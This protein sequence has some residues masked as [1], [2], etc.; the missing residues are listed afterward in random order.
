MRKALLAVLACLAVQL[1]AVAGENVEIRFSWWGAGERHENTL[2]AIKL[3]EAKNPGVTVKAEYMGWQGYVERLTTQIGSASEPDVMQINWAWIDMFSPDGKGLY[4][5]NQVKDSVNLADFSESMINSGMSGGALNGLPVSMTTR[6]WIWNKTM[7]DKAGAALPKTW[8]DLRDAG[9]KFKAMGDKFYAT[10]L[11]PIEG[12]YMVIAWLHDNFGGQIIHPTEPKIGVTEAQLVD[13]IRYFKSLFDSHAAVPAPVRTSIAG[14]YERPSEQ[15]GEFI[16]GTWAGTFVWNSMFGVRTGGAIERGSNMVLG[17]MLTEKGTNPKPDRI[18]RP[19]MMFAVSKNSKNP[20]LAAKLVS[21]LLTDPEGAKAM[22][23]ARGLPVAK[24]AYDTLM[25]EGLV[26][27]MDQEGQR[28]LDGATIVYTSPLFEHERIR[29]F[30]LNELEAV[31]HGSATP[32]QAAKN[33]MTN[34]QVI[35]DRLARRQ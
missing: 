19:A 1:A 29:S 15:V 21:F 7:W 31:S 33:I 25:K 5:L 4:D 16:D 32:E 20:A 35:L 27:E 30:L 11:E 23:M 2:A 8:N 24:T 17:E 34:G 13:G 10:D 9:P 26:S 18:G 28:Q 3:F 22:G 6:F 14:Q 12:L